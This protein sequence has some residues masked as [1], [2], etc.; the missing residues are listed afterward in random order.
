MDHL[1]E[2]LVRLLERVRPLLGWEGA[3]FLLLL[4]VSLWLL[5]GLDRWLGVSQR[6]RRLF[7]SLVEPK[8]QDYRSSVL[9]SRAE[10]R[11]DWLQAG[12]LYEQKGLYYRALDCYER[13]EEYHLCGEL[14]IRLGRKDYAAEWFLL[15]D[16]KRRAAQLFE[17]MGSFER[18]AEVHLDAGSS[19]D[20]AAAFARAGKHDRAAELYHQAQQFLRAAEA[21]EQAGDRSRAGES[22]ERQLSESGV[23]GRHLAASEKAELARIAMRAANCFEK[24]GQIERAERMLE[25]G[26]QHALAA[27]LAEKHGHFDRAADL[28]HRTGQISKAAEMYAR[29]GNARKAAALEGESRLSSGDAVAAAE[30]FLRGNDALRAA[31]VFES[32]GRFDRAADCYEQME[33]FGQAAESALRAGINDRAAKLFEKAKRPEQAA[34]LYV[35]I[36]DF[37][38]AARLFADASRYFD[39]AKA[40]AEANSED[41]MVDYLQ[42]VPTEDPHHRAAAVELARAFTRRGWSSLAIEKLE[43]VLGEEPVLPETLELWDV[44]ARA[45]EA[46]G[47]LAR[48]QELLHK[49][50]AVH[51]NYQDVAER[52][53]RLV[54]K[55]KEAIDRESSFRF[56]ETASG[57]GGLTSSSLN[58]DRYQVDTML[59]KGGMGAVYKAYDRLL[60]RSVAYKVIGERFARDPRARSHLLSEARAAAAL[61]H[62]NII[63]IFDV[64]LN[65]GQPFICMELVEGESYRT[66]VRKRGC[67]ELAEVL[68]FLVS[69]CQGLD[70]AHG[71]GIVHR[72]FKP[73]NVLLTVD[74]RVKIVDFGLA[75]SSPQ[76]ESAE[77]SLSGTPKYLSPEQARGEPTD[78][79]SDIYSLGATLYELLVGHPPFTEGNLVAHHLYTPAPPLRGER[80]EIPEALEEIVLHCLAKHPA[81]RFQSA[82][83]IIS[84]ATAAGLL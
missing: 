63:T 51:Y 26:G 16:E 40:A 38:R 30:S 46:Q 42:R 13:A 35:Q 34:E 41:L 68:H 79:R 47:E 7:L 55:L 31:E 33:A 12:L 19:L 49:I 32:I 14:C 76:K 67:L 73:S 1:P 3:K 37:A 75:H 48:A 83:E 29:A 22:Y 82:G 11:G 59:G 5:R 69:S 39:A 78:A 71:R 84:F 53:S 70:H 45:Y 8:L 15:G 60:K 2:S 17:E 64:G 4:L 80:S 28:Y 21:F 62:P 20:A 23:R 10:K 57:A 18:A 9:A 6:L 54:E 74:R 27:Q 43:M 81:E 36:G 58:G 66:L 44:L 52:H 50:M 24:A 56:E 77:S 65:E 61:N 72:D 25:E